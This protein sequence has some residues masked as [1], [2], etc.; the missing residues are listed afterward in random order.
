MALTA[1]TGL[2]VRLILVW[3]VAAECGES[4]SPGRCGLLWGRSGNAQTSC[5]GLTPCLWGAL[6]HLSS[7]GDSVSGGWGHILFSRLHRIL[8]SHQC[9][10]TAEFPVLGGFTTHSS[11]W[12]CTGEPC[13]RPGRR[14]SSQD[15]TAEPGGPDE[16]TSSLPAV[17]ESLCRFHQTSPCYSFWRVQGLL[18]MFSGWRSSIDQSL[19]GGDGSAGGFLKLVLQTCLKF[20]F[21]FSWAEVADIEF[22]PSGTTLLWFWFELKVEFA[23]DKAAICMTLCAGHHSGV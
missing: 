12:P 23:G 11:L 21:H 2:G 16:L 18:Q 10:H 17:V 19:R 9:L 22:F 8:H 15:K 6:G 5:K 3:L 4:L 13:K 14:L 1:S 7:S 20:S